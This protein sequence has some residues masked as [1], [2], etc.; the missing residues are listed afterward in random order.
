MAKKLGPTFGREVHK[1]GLNGK[2]FAWT[3][4]GEITGRQNLSA[5]ENAKLDALINQHDPTK[6]AT[7]LEISDRQYFQQLAIENVITQNQAI[8]AVAGKSIP[9]SMAQYIQ[10]LLPD[11]QFD[12]QML[13]GGAIL[14]RRDNSYVDGYR[15]F[16][17]WTPEYMDQV[18]Q[19][20]AQIGKGPT[21]PVA[22]IKPEQ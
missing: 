21:P 9:P 13:F 11:Q 7:P 17:G 6:T 10:K 5:A 20:A 8:D 2:E 3:K 15:D 19:R 14:V 4:D 12:A 16:M 18:F 22:E 1:A